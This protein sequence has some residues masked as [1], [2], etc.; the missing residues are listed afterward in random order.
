MPLKSK[1][2]DEQI[3]R[4]VRE[5]GR[6]ARAPDVARRMGVTEKTLYRWRQKFGGVELDEA[7]RVQQLE[8]ENALLKKLLAEQFLD[9]E[10]LR[11][12]ASKKKP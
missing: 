2:T 12:L 8:E 4:A 10:A 1:F 5:V 6:G 7:K 11:Q 3:L 9:N